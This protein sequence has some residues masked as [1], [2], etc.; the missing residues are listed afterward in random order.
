MSA[1]QRFAL[2]SGWLIRNIQHSTFCLTVPAKSQFE[3]PEQIILEPQWI[4]T[5]F[6]NYIMVCSEV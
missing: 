3:L 2:L 1:S 5:L 4:A 6:Y